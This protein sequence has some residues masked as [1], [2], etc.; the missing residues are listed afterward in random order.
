MHINVDRVGVGIEEADSPEEVI[1]AAGEERGGVA[2][3]SARAGRKRGMPTLAVR[4]NPMR[5]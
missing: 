1:K 5:V 4:M 3:G 2:E